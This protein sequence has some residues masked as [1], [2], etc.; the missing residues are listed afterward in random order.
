MQKDKAS[1]AS[2][3]ATPVPARESRVSA[4]AFSPRGGSI[5]V[6]ALVWGDLKRGDLSANRAQDPKPSH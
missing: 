3:S 1:A 6:T 5:E 4:K 2:C